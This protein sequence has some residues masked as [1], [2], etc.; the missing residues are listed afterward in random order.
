[1][2][3][4][5]IK[6]CCVKGKAL[7]TSGDFLIGRIRKTKKKKKN[8]PTTNSSA[9]NT[10]STRAAWPSTTI[11]PTKNVS[12][13]YY[14][15]LF[16]CNGNIQTSPATSA[17]LRSSRKQ[18]SG[19]AQKRRSGR[20]SSDRRFNVLNRFSPKT[21]NKFNIVSPWG[22]IIIPLRAKWAILFVWQQRKKKK[23]KPVLCDNPKKY[24][25]ERWLLPQNKHLSKQMDPVFKM[26]HE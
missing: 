21:K 24:R 18:R 13:D 2:I 19:C 1:M 14:F 17:G 22:K 16:F 10:V 26:C 25:A 3:K 11:H 6:G 7:Q 8:P 4:R 5:V 23:K 12:L 20:L 9:L 15:I